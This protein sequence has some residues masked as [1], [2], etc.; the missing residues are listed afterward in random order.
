MQIVVQQVSRWMV[1]VVL[2][3]LSADQFD[4]FIFSKKVCH[5][6]SVRSPPVSV[7]KRLCV[8]AW[9]RTTQGGGAV[10]AARA[11]AGHGGGPGAD[12]ECGHPAS[13]YF[14]SLPLVSHQSWSEG[15]DMNWV[16][17]GPGG[18][19]HGGVTPPSDQERRGLHAR[20]QV[21]LRWETETNRE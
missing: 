6:G 2:P 15:G 16:T 4:H 13:V 14:I 18:G 19:C 7:P 17:S 11:E 20:C 12:G 3:V 10:R 1:F 8:V 21:L 5:N 9:R